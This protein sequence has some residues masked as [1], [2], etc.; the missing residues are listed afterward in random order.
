MWFFT[1]NK[2]EKFEIKRSYNHKYNGKET[3]FNNLKK[4][5]HNFFP[6]NAGS[7]LNSSRLKNLESHKNECIKNIEKNKMVMGV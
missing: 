6:Y 4:S 5:K 7:I 2:N 3:V 1:T